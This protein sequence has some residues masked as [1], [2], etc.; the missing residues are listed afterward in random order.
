LGAVRN[1]SS[2]YLSGYGAGT[3][4]FSETITDEFD[5]WVAAGQSRG[6]LIAATLVRADTSKEQ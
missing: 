4:V 6:G 3:G 5:R 1:K 2:G